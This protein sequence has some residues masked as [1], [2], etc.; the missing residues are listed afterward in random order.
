LVNV[1]LF[2]PNGLKS[3]MDLHKE[4]SWSS[5]IRTVIEEKLDEFEEAEAL[6][7]K[8]R[9]SEKDVEKLASKVDAAMARHAEA[10]LRETRR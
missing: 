10:L 1:T 8:S 3:R 9:L 6:A 7:K 5:A 2:M 4:V